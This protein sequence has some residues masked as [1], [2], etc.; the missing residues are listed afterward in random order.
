MWL[1]VFI[2]LVTFALPAACATINPDVDSL[3]SKTLSRDLTVCDVDEH[4][5]A[6]LLSLDYKAFDQDLFG[7]WRAIDYRPG[8]SGAAA[9]LILQYIVADRDPPL[10]TGQLKLLNWHAG[11]TKA[12]IAD[13]VAI[14]LFEKAYDKRDDAGLSDWDLY[15]LGTISFL[16]R[17]KAMLTSAR[18]RLAARAVSESEQQERQKFLDDNPM[19]TMPAG[20]VTEPMNLPVLNA[21]LDCYDE[22][23]IVAYQECPHRR[24]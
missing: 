7:G 14:S 5:H 12:Y 11:Q 20:F 18:D 1:R 10:S 13:S 24:E 17:D 16:S 15:V 6:R 3:S 2:G 8:C 4:E 22:A 19:I 21:L 9:E 23:Y